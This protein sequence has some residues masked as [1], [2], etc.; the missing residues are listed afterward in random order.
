[1]YDIALN[2]VIKWSWDTTIPRTEIIML[3][4]ENREKRLEVYQPNNREIRKG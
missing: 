3:E 4:E 2:V 1:M